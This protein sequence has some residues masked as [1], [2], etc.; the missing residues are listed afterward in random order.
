MA[1]VGLQVLE[2]LDD[3]E[4]TR[5][6]LDPPDR[7][8]PGLLVVAPRAGLAAHRDRLDALDDGVVRVDVAVEPPDLAVRD[9]VDAR[10]LHVA[11]RRVGR[12]VHHL[13]EIA[14]ADLAR[15]VGLHRGEPPAGVTVGA[16]DRGGNQGKVAHVVRSLYTTPAL[17]TSWIRAGSPR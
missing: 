2:L 8:V 5:R 12:V 15:L 11:D 10:L 1:R 16:D 9:D 13:L 6:C 7:L 17:T 4:P 14:G 3:A